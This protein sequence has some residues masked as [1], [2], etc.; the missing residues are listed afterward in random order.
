MT[1]RER[2]ERPAA[3]RAMKNPQYVFR[4]STNLEHYTAEAFTLR[5]FDDRYWKAFKAFLK[6]QGI[7]RIDPES[8]AGGAKALASPEKE[9]DC[10][11]LLREIQ[12]SI[13]LHH[14][15][16]IMIFTHQDCGAYGGA[17]RF[18]NDEEQEFAFHCV[19][20]ARARKA[21]ALRFPNLAVE[22]YFINAQG[23]IRTDG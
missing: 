15:P 14:T 17:S 22:S 12:K 11:F 23:V 13:A 4:I 16:K 3:N 2:P 8:V 19:E 20:H 5:C 1:L 6:S 9:G 21:L 7:C 10:D 18:E